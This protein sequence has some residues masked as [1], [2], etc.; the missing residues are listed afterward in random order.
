MAQGRGSRSGE[1]SVTSRSPS[2]EPSSHAEQE[3]ERG[4]RKE[5]SELDNLNNGNN[6]IYF[7]TKDEY[8]QTFEIDTNYSKDLFVVFGLSII[9][10]GALE[11][12]TSYILEKLFNAR[13]W[14]YS[15]ERFNIKGRICHTTTM[16]TRRA[17][18]HQFT[19][20]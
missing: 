18:P 12:F 20:L 8:N 3:T 2:G 9:L 16:R 14:D 13:W 7:I 11:Y 19:E 10:C 15:N 5:Y 17:V 1:A 4:R 6:K